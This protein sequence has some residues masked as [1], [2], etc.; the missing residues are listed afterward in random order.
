MR[1]WVQ[2]RAI[3]CTFQKNIKSNIYDYRSSFVKDFFFVFCLTILVHGNFLALVSA[4][5]FSWANPAITIRFIFRKVKFGLKLCLNMLIFVGYIDF[6]LSDLFFRSA[7]NSNKSPRGARRPAPYRPPP[8]PYT[9]HQAIY[10][11]TPEGT[12]YPPWRGPARKDG[13]PPPPGE[14]KAPSRFGPSPDPTKI[15]CFSCFKFGHKSPQCP[16]KQS[17]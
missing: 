4:F 17:Q 14:V 11:L 10:E 2:V 3:P 16:E 1:S 15:R 5:L 12:A 6:Y 13:Q 8:L 9:R 7:Y